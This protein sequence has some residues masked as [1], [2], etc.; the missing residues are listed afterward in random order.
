M[1]QTCGPPQSVICKWK[2]ASDTACRPLSIML[3][4]VAYYATSSSRFFL[5]LCSVL[6]IMLV[7]GNYATFS[8]YAQK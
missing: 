5:K 1:K 3:E 2:V 6:K 7:F 8:M 4:K